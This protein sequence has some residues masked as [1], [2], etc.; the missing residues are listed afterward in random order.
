MNAG[1]I[2]APFA[3]EDVY[4]QECVAA[5]SKDAHVFMPAVSREFL[6]DY[7]VC[8]LDQ[9][10]CLFTGWGAPQLNRKLLDQMPRL[11]A[12]FFGA[13]SVRDL[14]T[15]EFWERNISLTIAGEINAQPVAEYTLGIILLSLKRAWYYARKVRELHDYPAEDSGVIGNYNAKIGLISYGLVARKLRT[16]LHPFNLQVM[17]Y[18]PFID[19]DM[20]RADEAI[21]ASLEEIFS[22]CDVVSLHTPLLPE[23]TG[24]ITGKLIGMLKKGATF[25]NTA[26][27][28]IV[29]EKELIKALSMRPD[30][31]AVLDVV[32]NEPPEKGSPLYEL[33]NVL[34]TPHIAGSMGHERRRIG[35][36][37][38]D[39]FR[40]FISGQPMLYAMNPRT[41]I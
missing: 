35:R 29:D 12:V 36:A 7:G 13:G 16:L 4:G 34:L 39:E 27:G 23:T 2:L 11:K 1:F 30:L 17:V 18:D 15:D 32:N 24:L 26:R 20:L 5:I 21:P 19:D 10:D 28:G 37:M 41:L 38:V 9:V 14:V 25:V 31:Q 3:F 40:R 33:P 8:W 22:Q 6:S